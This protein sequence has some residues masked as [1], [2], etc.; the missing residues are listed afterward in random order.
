MSKAHDTPPAVPT[1]RLSCDLDDTCLKTCRHKGYEEVSGDGL[2]KLNAARV[3]AGM[4]GHK[5]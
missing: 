4:D 1:K 3:N 5:F 2:G